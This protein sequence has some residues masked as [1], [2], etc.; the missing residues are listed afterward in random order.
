MFLTQREN[1]CLIDGI[2]PSYVLA[3]FTKNNIPGNLPQDIVKI[4][5]FNKS[6]RLAYLNQTH[7]DRVNV[8][9]SPGVYDGDAL[10]TDLDNCVLAIKTA[11]CLPLFFLSTQLGVIGILHM[12]WRP[13]EKGILENIPYDLSSFIVI[14]GVG[15]RFC[16]YQVGKEFLD[17]VR[18]LKYVKDYNNKFYFDPVEFAKDELLKLGLKEKNFFDLDICSLC[19]FSDFFSYR[20]NK[21]SLRTISFIVKNE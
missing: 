15:L 18:L 4:S 3:G 5:S 16:C 6:V 14:S 9:K 8:I 17:Y 13:A 1:H 2:L 11:D 20:R 12:G 19:N 7:S 10:F 21:T